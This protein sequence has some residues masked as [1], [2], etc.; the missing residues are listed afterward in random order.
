MYGDLKVMNEF[1]HTKRYL[2][3]LLNIAIRYLEDMVN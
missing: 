3:G 1:N 2:D